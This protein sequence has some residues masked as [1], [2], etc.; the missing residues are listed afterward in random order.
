[1]IP[2]VIWTYIEGLRRHDVVG[3]AETITVDLAFVTPS[4]RLTRDEFLQMLRALYTGFP[5]WHYDHSPPE[6]R[7]GAVAVRWQQ[8]GTHTGIFAMPGMAPVPATGKTVRIPAQ[9][10]LYVVREGKIAEIRPEAI[11]GGAPGGILEQ[12]GLTAPPR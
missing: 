5:D 6:E 7:D 11:P 8:G 9:Y 4:R 1:M 12:I 2:P 3:I 10:F